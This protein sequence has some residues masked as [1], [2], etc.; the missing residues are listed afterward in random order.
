MEEIKNKIKELL[1]LNSL[2]RE[3]HKA[4]REFIIRKMKRQE[5][6]FNELKVL[7]KKNHTILGRIVKF[8]QADSYA[9]YVITK[10]NKHTVRL[11]LV[12]FCDGLVDDRCGETCNANID[13]I[14]NLIRGYDILDNIFSEK[15]REE[16]LQARFDNVNA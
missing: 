13:Y 14:N 7:A 16:R 5:A 12:N 6:L 10:V 8:P 9:V 15:K 4:Y 11:E 3:S 1:Q 2:Q